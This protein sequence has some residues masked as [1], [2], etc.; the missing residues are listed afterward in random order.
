LTDLL[1]GEKRAQENDEQTEEA[2][3]SMQYYVAEE[4]TVIFLL[5]YYTT[6]C[7]VLKASISRTSC[8][9]W[10]CEDWV[11]RPAWAAEETEMC[12]WRANT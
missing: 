10:V 5:M 6:G 4:G 11:C 2:K 9:M 8:G 1:K 7:R 12:D 3:A